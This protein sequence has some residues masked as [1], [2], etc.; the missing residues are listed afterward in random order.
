MLAGLHILAYVVLFIWA[1]LAP[2]FSSRSF[3]HMT[4]GVGYSNWA[5]K[6]GTIKVASLSNGLLFRLS[7]NAVWVIAHTYVRFLSGELSQT[8]YIYT[9]I[10]FCTCFLFFPP[11]S[12]SF[13]FLN[14]NLL[15][16]MPNADNCY[17]CRMPGHWARD[18]P[19]LPHHRTT[20]S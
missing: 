17:S 13:F 19:F 18:C 2:V 3:G 5:L 8:Y 1:T 11:F 9:H 12:V 14:F 15:L 20:K 4:E 16:G 10:L 7:A 6:H